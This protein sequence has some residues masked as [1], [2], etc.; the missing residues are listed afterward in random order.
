[1]PLMFKPEPMPVEVISALA[2]AALGVE[3]E[4]LLEGMTELM[5]CV[6]H[7]VARS[8]GK[9]QQYL[10]KLRTNPAA[11]QT[12]LLTRTPESPRL[13]AK[14]ANSLAENSPTTSPVAGLIC[15][16]S[17]SFDA[18]STR[19]SSGL[20]ESLR[21]LLSRVTWFCSSE[22]P[23]AAGPAAAVADATLPLCGNVLPPG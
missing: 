10:S 21:N 17:L 3:P 22:L 6:P 20:P 16:M 7:Q 23:A 2:L 18:G 13:R 11:N 14:A 9:P 8:I 5:A 12:R 1:M 4:A 19:N 15:W